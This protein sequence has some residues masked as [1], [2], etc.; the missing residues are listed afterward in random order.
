MYRSHW[1]PK[2]ERVRSVVDAKSKDFVNT[3][4]EALSRSIADNYIIES[5]S[6]QNI[7]TS[8]LRTQIEKHFGNIE[9]PDNSHKVY[10]MDWVQRYIDE[11]PEKLYRGK[12]ISLRTIQHYQTTF[13]KVKSYLDKKDIKLRHEDIN[14][15]FYRNLVAFLRK[16]DKLSDNSI[17]GHI[18]NIKLWARNIDIEGLPI[19][20]EYRHSEFIAPQAKTYDVYLKEREIAIIRDLDLSDNSRLS[21]TRDLFI[22]GLRTGL[23]ISDFMRL[24]DINIQK[25]QIQITTAKTGN[26]VIIPLHKDVKQVLKNNDG[27]PSAI[28]DQKFNKYVKELCES[29]GI[30]QKVEGAKM[31]TEKK[32]DGSKISRKKKGIYPKYEL[33]SSHICR[34]SFA[35]NL[36]GKLPNMTIM[37]ITGHKT[38]GSIPKIFK[39]QQAGTC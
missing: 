23:R 35:T 29:A 5:N 13:N 3:E 6:R 34:R 20:P 37:S 27:L 17:G 9:N 19:C 24:K 28:S 8:W 4:L 26:D 16:E 36:Y 12:P 33:I 10:F 30:N 15:K 21:N 39:N 25:E 11:A 31:I 2:K 7:G 22:I 38:E 32:E 1:S 18:N 14:L